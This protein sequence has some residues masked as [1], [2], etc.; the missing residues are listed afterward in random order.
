MSLFDVLLPDGISLLLALGFVLLTFLTSAFTAAVGVGGGVLLLAVMATF[1]S[2]AL[3][4]PVHGAVQVGTNAGRA[5]VLARH[6]EP[7]IVALFTAGGVAGV[8]VGAAVFASLSMATL[9][10]LLA[11]FILFSVWVPVGRAEPIPLAGYLGVGAVASFCTMFIGGTGPFLAAFLSPDRYPRHKVVATHASCMALQHLLKVAAFGWL[12]FAFGP[13]L[14][15]VVAMIASGFL[16]T[17]VGRRILDWLPE[18]AFRQAFRAVLTALA[19]RLLWAAL[20]G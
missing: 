13:W 6:V 18:R 15:L 20:S 3:L 12:G 1:L 11:G 2:P 7:K 8:A 5:L 4:L 19:L 9:Q 16:G 17:L 14:G 10:L